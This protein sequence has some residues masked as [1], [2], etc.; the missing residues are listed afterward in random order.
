VNRTLRAWVFTLTLGPSLAQA[1]PTYAQ[2]RQ[3]HHTSNTEVRDRHGEVI[4]QVRT[5]LKTRTGPWLTL[6][7]F[8]PALV[9][10]LIRSEDARFF[11]HGGVDWQAVAGGVR[12][13]AQGGRRGASTLTMQLAGLLDA[14]LTQKKGG[15]SV[16][17]KIDQAAS[18]MAIERQWTK[19]QILEAYLNLVPVR[20][21]L[22]GMPV[23]SQVLFEKSAHGVSREQ[24]AVLVALLRAPNAAPPAVAQRACRIV[25]DKPA[26]GACSV[27]EGAVRI[28]LSK[29][30]SG[31][32]GSAVAPHFARRAQAQGITNTSLDA[33]LQRIATESLKR[34][35]REL[36]TR[37]VEDGAVVVLDNA[38]GQ[39]LAWVGSTG[40]LS[41][42]NQVDFVT[43]RRQAG[44]TLKPFLYGLAIAEHKLT[45][46]S[47]L[48]DNPVNLATAN[49]LY[50]P[51]NYDKHFAGPVSVRTA[52]ASSL[53][54]PAV[55]TAVMVTPERLFGTLKGM[56][57]G[58]RESGD[59]YGYSLALGSAEVSLLD[60]TNAYRALANGGRASAVQ[61][62]AIK[63]SAV[64]F[65]KPV[66]P[67][68]VAF[69]LGDI[70][71]DRQARAHTFGLTSPL[72][73][74]GWAAVK[75]GTSKD[76]RDN[77]CIGWSDR[78]TVGVWVGNASGASM[79]DVSG[80]SGAAP[81]WNEIM[82]A[83]HRDSVS[84]APRPPSGTALRLAQ[85]RFDNDIEPPRDEWFF[86]SEGDA[87]TDVV[88]VRVAGG[89][90]GIVTPT[91]G[92]LIAIDPDIP[93]ARQRM[94]FTAHAPRGAVLLLDGKAMATKRTGMAVLS[95]AWQPMPGS[96]LIRLVDVQG[97]ELDKV[98][99]Q[100]RGATLKRRG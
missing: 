70:L 62:A 23:A 58:L 22:V 47:L 39:V 37:N 43:A 93:V 87:S 44:S 3:S 50:V 75:T 25:Y 71:S 1:V 69:I 92:T 26:E 42:A 65:G 55:R 82:R 28:A 63:T 8:S 14:D 46:S 6:D 90:T 100:V 31:Q 66:L 97:Q 7:Q 68:E 79:W 10:T 54:V 59:Y 95:A 91:D 41:A 78:Y 74:K 73:T 56:G 77:W 2:V 89:Q 84:M 49:G 4:G 72:A 35:V 85:V 40:E 18:A 21:E 32:P 88:Q 94:V 61:F 34:H 36:A 38:T 11:E 45:A 12:Q 83:L 57:I 76:M 81:V 16:L 20:S 67:P 60:L 98:Q 86:A 15:R 48:D 13:Q 24:A 30:A 5:D 17:Q 64:N 52:L 9:D 80:V 33:R 99:I 27:L 19:G 96:H 53:N 51:Q 29:I